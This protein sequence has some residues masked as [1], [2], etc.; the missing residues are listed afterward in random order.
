MVEC[1]A[2]GLALEDCGDDAC[3]AVGEDVEYHAAGEAFEGPADEDAEV[4]EEDGEL[5]EVD[6]ELVDYLA[7]PE[8]LD[9]AG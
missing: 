9:G 3:G 5:G 2:D 1:A 8:V 7:D 4:E 6:G